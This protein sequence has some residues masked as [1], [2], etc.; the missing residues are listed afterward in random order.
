[1]ARLWAVASSWDSRATYGSPRARLFALPEVS[2]GIAATEGGTALPRK[3][4]LAL[5]LEIGLTADPLPARR[6]LALG[7]VN[8]VVPA[9]DVLPTTLA[10]A[11]RIAAHSPAA[12][13]ATKRLMHRSLGVDQSVLEAE[14]AAVT[15]ALLSGPDAA[16]GVA[17]F[18]AKRPPR[19]ADPPVTEA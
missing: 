16:E 3:I 8:R 17:A 5:A 18:L 12:V 14:E 2:R 1:M 10:L 11:E 9:P 19:W 7:V 4:P 6:A 15:T 13:R